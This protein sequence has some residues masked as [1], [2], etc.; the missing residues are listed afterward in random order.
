MTPPPGAPPA[1]VTGATGLVGGAIVLELL[2][3]T[4]ADVFCLARDGRHE[5]AA[6]RVRRIL[7]RMATDYGMRDVTDAIAA[8]CRVLPGDMTAPGCGIPEHLLPSE[9]G[10]VWHAAAS[11]KFRDRDRA[12]IELHN[13]TGTRNVT[14]LAVRLGAR[15]FDLVSTAYVVGDRTGLLTEEPVPADCR[16][17]NAYEKSKMAGEALVRG[18]PVDTVRILRPG[19]VIGHSETLA[20]PTTFGLYT[21]VDELTAFRAA[22]EPRLGNYLDH[23]PVAMLGDPATRGNLIPVDAVAASAVRLGLAGAP[24]GVYHLT[25][26]EPTR[27]GEALIALTAALGIRAPRWVSDRAELTTIDDVLNRELDFQGAYMRQ[28]KV[29]DATRARQYCADLLTVPLGPE[30]IGEFVTRYLKDGAAEQ[31]RALRKAAPRV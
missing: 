21:F 3:R 2:R 26:S 23:Y 12:E 11:L 5:S 4:D 6:E 9:V 27:L 15:A 17:N 22:I 18:L 25:N 20:A 29:F 24:G 7:T 28:D 10:E 16:P 31:V 30:R 8:R 13:V 19:I 14:G 1:L